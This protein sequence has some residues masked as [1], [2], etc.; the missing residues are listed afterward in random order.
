MSCNHDV[1]TNFF[2]IYEVVRSFTFQAVGLVWLTWYFVQLPERS[3]E[4]KWRATTST[5]TIVTLDLQL[6][7][8]A[9]QLESNLEIKNFVIELGELDVFTAFKMLE[10]IINGNGLD[11]AFKE[12]LI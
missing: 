7:S 2:P 12:A 9:L 10:K 8:K 4:N 5:K 11:K 1:K 6:Y 3:S